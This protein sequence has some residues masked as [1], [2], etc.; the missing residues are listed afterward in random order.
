MIVYEKVPLQPLPT[1]DNVRCRRRGPFDDDHAVLRQ[2]LGR[3]FSGAAARPTPG[4]LQAWLVADERGPT[5]RAWC[6]DVLVAA[7]SDPWFGLR[8][9]VSEDAVSIHDLARVCTEAQC[10]HAP[11]TDWLNRYA[12]QSP[13]VLESL[14][15]PAWAVA[16]LAQAWLLHPAHDH[17]RSPAAGERRLTGMMPIFLGGTSK[18]NVTKKTL[19]RVELTLHE[20]DEAERPIARPP[21]GGRPAAV[22]RT[23]SW[24]RREDGWHAQIS[25]ALPVGFDDD[26]A[27]GER[28]AKAVAEAYSE[29]MESK[30]Q[31][32]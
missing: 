17:P 15:P 9:L 2:L 7:A 21:D 29:H 16:G 28:L 23:G 25:V 26:P 31:E 13:E 12:N 20:V 8:A 22:A 24:V 11:L 6:I 30:E 32:P 3:E 1:F 27:L 19:G 4:Q 14:M 10:Q 18:T 5:E